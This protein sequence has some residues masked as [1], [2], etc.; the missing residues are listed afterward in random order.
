MTTT[1]ERPAPGTRPANRRQ[2]ILAAATD[3]FYR[4][5]YA[6]VGMSDIAAAVA[7]GPSA[8]YR[9]FRGK[10]ELLAAVTAESI[11]AVGATL[12]R[13]DRPGVA[14]L[15]Q[16]IA[17]TAVEQRRAGVIWWR[18][19]RYLS[20]ESHREIR[21]ALHESRTRLADLIGA[22]R[23]EVTRP[24]QE[25]LAVCALGI[26]TSISFHTATLPGNRM[27]TTLTRLIEPALTVPIPARIDARPSGG[28]PRRPVVSRRDSVLEA[29]TELFA[30]QG[31]SN[32]SMDD[33]GQAIGIAGPSL[34][35]HFAN[36]AEILVAAL[37][38]GNEWLRLDLT[39]ALSG[40]DD[41]GA[42]LSRVFTGYV[43]FAFEQPNLV[44]LLL[45]EGG[46][47]PEPERHRL[48][49]AQHEYLAEW[50]HLARI[51]DPAVT[52]IEAKITV[53]AAIQLVNEIAI[54][55]RGRALP[56]AEQLLT[57]IGRHLLL[58]TAD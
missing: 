22:A 18:E 20:D 36:K 24:Q 26:A 4:V 12:D 29:A 31:F 53:Q 21:S 58:D 3:L 35:N 7:I 5:G 8:L 46:E 51:A 25:F 33:I 41:A 52:E 11:A 30:R 48:R 23:P 34:Y 37:S 1:D 49:T 47:L 19:A 43:A 2:L 17:R 57:A 6:N 50:I 14:E 45:T 13:L 55:R 56:G 15:S 42:T 54:A 28:Q 38:R 16:A 27:V 32:V 44:H 10:Q 9:H 39:R 40:V